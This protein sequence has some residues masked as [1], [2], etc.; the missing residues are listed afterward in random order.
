LWAFDAESNLKVVLVEL[1]RVTA[2]ARGPDDE[3]WVASHNGMIWRIDPVTDETV[4][5]ERP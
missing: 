1:E 4:S 5:G 2:V 3:L